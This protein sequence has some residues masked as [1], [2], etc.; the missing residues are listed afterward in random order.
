MS[1]KDLKNFEKNEIAGN[2]DKLN[3]KSGINYKDSVHKPSNNN[4][5]MGNDNEGEF[6]FINEKVVGNKKF[7]PGK[8]LLFLVMCG[9]IIGAIACMVF[10]FMK[11][12]LNKMSDDKKS[13]EEINDSKVSESNSTTEETSPVETTKTIEERLKNMGNSVVTLC[14]NA[15]D[16]WE[17]I[18]QNNVNY[19][20]GLITVLNDKIRILTTYD[21]I[22]DNREV[23]VYLGSRGYKGTVDHV[24]EKYGLATVLI[25]ADDIKDEDK[26][27]LS[28]AEYNPDKEIEPGEEITFMGNPYGK[29]KFV[30][31]GSLTSV[32][33]TYNIVV[34]KHF[35]YHL[36]WSILPAMS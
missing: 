12:Y 24:S 18:E 17:S 21:F 10:V 31:K 15:E 27:T 7:T 35:L 8:L 13:T 4:T 16:E 36:P 33:N 26:E 11:P 34:T 3:S 1:E 6:K 32:G 20:S 25:N 22:K 14:V 23:T 19:G 2:T 30:A 28:A 29:E 9:I 5:H